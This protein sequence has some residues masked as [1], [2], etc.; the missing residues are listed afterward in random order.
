MIDTMTNT[1]I[2][3]L[4]AENWLVVQVDRAPV[5]NKET[6]LHALYQACKF[7]AYFGFNWDALHDVFNDP[8]W[9]EEQHQGVI[10]VFNDFALLKTRA[11]EVSETF[12]ELTQDTLVPIRVVQ[13]YKNTALPI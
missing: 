4:E 13:L 12:L 11:P 5:F 6:L 8:S 7:H 3:A 2:T 1:E 10:L 9:L